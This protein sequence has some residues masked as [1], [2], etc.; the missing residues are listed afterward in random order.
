[1]TTNLTAKENEVK[2]SNDLR[3]TT[4][5]IVGKEKIV[6]KIRLNDECKNGHQDFAITADIY[7]KKGNGQYYYSRGGCCHD[8]ILK[9]FPKFKLFVNLHLSDYSGAPMYAVENGFYHLQKSDKQ[10]VIDYLRISEE[11]YN[12]LIHAEDKDYFKYL[13]YSEG[14]VNQW[15]KEATL[16]IQ[17]IEEL[18]GSEFVNDSER[19]QIAPLTNEEKT[20]IESRLRDGYYTIDAINLRKEEAKQ[21]AKNKQITDL[22]SSF[23]KEKTKLEN[24]LNIKIFL[25]ENDFSIE[26]FIYYNHTNE[27]VFNWKNYGEQF[28][29]SEFERLM[30]LDL[31]MLPTGLNFKFGE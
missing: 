20:L 26:N 15:L 9:R 8:E 2:R 30:L 13:L 25:L 28:S 4:T 16:A 10:T 17:L 11:Q 14:I 21:A 29:K 12:K 31:S 23:M 19:S 5:K 6:V 22:Q 7:E 1:M 24:E 18:T 3:Y 27:G